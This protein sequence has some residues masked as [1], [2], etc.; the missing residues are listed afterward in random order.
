MGLLFLL[1]LPVY[2]LLTWAIVAG[3]PGTEIETPAQIAADER[4]RELAGR[5]FVVVA[6]ALLVGGLGFLCAA[7][8][9]RSLP[10]R[11]V[12]SDEASPGIPDLRD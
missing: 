5:F 2:A 3:A 8:V 1:V 11:P 10:L 6:P 7:L 12:R 4:N 9:V